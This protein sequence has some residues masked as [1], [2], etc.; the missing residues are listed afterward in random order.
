MNWTLRIGATLD[1]IRGA[2]LHVDSADLNLSSVCGIKFFVLLI[3]EGSR[4]VSGS[5][6]KT[7]GE[8]AELFM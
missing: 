5:H 2:V 6:V 8:P 1:T 7:R 3:G 4:H